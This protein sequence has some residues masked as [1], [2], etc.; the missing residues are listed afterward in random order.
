LKKVNKD[1]QLE[2]TDRLRS[3]L[4]ILAVLEYRDKENW[5]DVHPVLRKLLN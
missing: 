2:Y 5:C 4:Q 3:L 1:N